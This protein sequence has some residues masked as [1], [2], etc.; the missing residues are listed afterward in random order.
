VPVRSRFDNGAYSEDDV[1]FSGIPF[2]VVVKKYEWNAGE[3]GR[4]VVEAQ[5]NWD[6][7]EFEENPDNNSMTYFVDVAQPEQE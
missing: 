5:I 3:P 7:R 1:S 4:K 6:K 2:E